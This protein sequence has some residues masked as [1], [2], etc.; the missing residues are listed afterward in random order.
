MHYAVGQQAF[1]LHPCK[2]YCE[3][4]GCQNICFVG[5]LFIS[6]IDHILIC[7]TFFTTV[8]FFACYRDKEKKI[9]DLNGGL[10]FRS[11]VTTKFVDVVTI[12]NKFT[13]Q[14]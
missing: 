3:E 7:L 2:T 1:L 6:D 13:S 14:R 5:F 8:F 9:I 10:Y 12:L 4:N 11:E